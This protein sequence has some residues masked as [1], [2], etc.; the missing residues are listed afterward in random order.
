MAPRGRG[1]KHPGAGVPLITEG[2]VLWLLLTRY[3]VMLGT[4]EKIL[5]HLLEMMRLDCQ[6]T[7]SGTSCSTSV[8]PRLFLG[9]LD[10]V[11]R[12]HL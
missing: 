9:P 8:M 5:E 11:L 4:P 2:C 1:I 3:T 12:L 6:F 10:E 7:E